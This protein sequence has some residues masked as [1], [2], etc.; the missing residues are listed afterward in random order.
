MPP[1]SP[2]TTTILVVEDDANARTVY[3]TALS[4]AGYTVVAVEDG[5]AALHWLETHHIDGVVLD[6]A[7]PRLSG[8]D[9]Q[10]ESA[11]HSDSRDIPIVVVTGSDELLEA[12]NVRCVLRKP[13][14][15][16]VLVETVK[17]CIPPKGGFSTFLR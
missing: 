1:A 5:L 12:E 3:R 8:H 6:L 11:S 13:V 10:R 9:V 14:D 2:T 15:P 4:L 7:L 16:D 17:R